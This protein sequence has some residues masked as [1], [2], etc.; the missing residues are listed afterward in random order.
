MLHPVSMRTFWIW[1]I[2]V[3]NYHVNWGTFWH[4]L[5]QCSQISELFTLATRAK[6]YCQFTRAVL[7]RLVYVVLVVAVVIT[8]IY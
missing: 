6:R 2:E 8:N 5:Q 4:S 3:E 7:F 1:S